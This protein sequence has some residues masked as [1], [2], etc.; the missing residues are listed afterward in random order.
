MKTRILIAVLIASMAFP[1]FSYGF[2][3][4]QYLF[5]AVSN[6]LGLDRGP[7]PKTGP[8]GTMADFGSAQRPAPNHPDAH[9]IHIQAE[10]F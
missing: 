1:S 10:G 4:L 9:R 7:I 3:L 2:G 5:D 6:Q 8:R